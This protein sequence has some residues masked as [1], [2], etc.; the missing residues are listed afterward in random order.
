MKWWICALNPRGDAARLTVGLLH[1]GATKPAPPL[2]G[3]D[4]ASLGSGPMTGPRIGLD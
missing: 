4:V 3:D 2:P 1:A